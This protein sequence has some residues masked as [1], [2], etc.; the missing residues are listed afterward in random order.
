MRLFT[1]EISRQKSSLERRILR[2]VPT[3]ETQIS[4]SI[5]TLNE[6]V[7]F[8]ISAAIMGVQMGDLS[9]LGWVI[10]WSIRDMLAE[11]LYFLYV[12]LGSI[13]KTFLSFQRS[14]VCTESHVIVTDVTS[15][16]FRSMH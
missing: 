15:A 5:Y 8:F 11:S 13:C 4:H 10:G 14:S 2:M 7:D 9:T 1:R 3:Q 16:T 12:V 6:V